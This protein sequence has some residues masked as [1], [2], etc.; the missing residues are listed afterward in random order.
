MVKFGTLCFSGLGNWFPGVGSTPLVGGCAVAATHKQNRGSLAQML[1][2]GESSSA[3]PHL[4]QKK[5]D[6]EKKET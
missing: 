6:K 5:T 4:I 1:A 3:K 2:Q